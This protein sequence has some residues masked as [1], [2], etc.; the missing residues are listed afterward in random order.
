MKYLNTQ[1]N[2]S[3]TVNKVQFRMNTL[4]MRYGKSVVFTTI[5]KKN[6]DNHELL[7]H[8]SNLQLTYSGFDFK[9]LLNVIFHSELQQLK[10]V[11]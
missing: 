2:Q 6:R 9:S 5:Y 8:L 3:L 7:R 4:I 11:A 10:K 1:L